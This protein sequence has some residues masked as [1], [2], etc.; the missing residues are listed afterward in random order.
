MKDFVNFFGLRYSAVS[1]ND[2]GE[3]RQT[4][5]SMKNPRSLKPKSDF[6]RLTILDSFF[7]HREAGK[8]ARYPKCK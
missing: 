5:K 6:A 1:T 7:H 8:R 4:T 3:N 2:A